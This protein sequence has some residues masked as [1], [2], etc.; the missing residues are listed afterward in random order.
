MYEKMIIK[1]VNSKYKYS[2]KVSTYL[3]KIRCM[4]GKFLVVT[5]CKLNE[6]KRETITRKSI[7][8]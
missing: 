1:T 4:S 7:L 8:E 6:G 2:N 5:R 3:G